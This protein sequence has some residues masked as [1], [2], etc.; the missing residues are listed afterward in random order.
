MYGGELIYQAS[1]EFGSIEVVEFDK[2]IRSLHF[3][4]KTSQS[5]M[6][7]Y[8]PVALIH[9][10]TQAM[11][12][13]LAWNAPGRVLML[14]L[15]AGSLT[16]FL[17]HHY[18]DIHIDAVDIRA[19]VIEVAKEYFSLPDASQRF[20]IYYSSAEQFLK[21]V[22]RQTYD[23]I[24]V[25]LFLTSTSAD[26]TFDISHSV[27]QLSQYLS[28]TGYLCINLLGNDYIKAPVI[29]E[30]LK[31]FHL[32]VYAIQIDKSNTILIASHND[33]NRSLMNMDYS[34]IESQLGLHFKQYTGS[35]TK[36]L[37]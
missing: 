33:I 9:K 32:N 17:L 16:K 35:I 28:S 34:S 29:N 14:G 13:P 24:L 31:V 22:P 21:T 3:G 27:H 10:Y 36:V 25:D 30:L 26:V 2:C 37:I 8:N 19:K 11:L 5:V 15:G 23:L 1:D 12:L 7:L 4:N 20:N 18:P 6:F